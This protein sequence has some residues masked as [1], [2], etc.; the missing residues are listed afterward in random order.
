MGSCKDKSIF[1]MKSNIFSRQSTYSDLEKK[2][3]KATGE[4]RA[5][6]FMRKDKPD[7]CPNKVFN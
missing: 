7:I 6:V 4:E 1:G 5:L 2:A 3:S